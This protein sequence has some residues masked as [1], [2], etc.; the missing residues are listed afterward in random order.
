MYPVLQK[1]QCKH[2]WCLGKTF[3][4]SGQ[5]MI[6]TPHVDPSGELDETL[7]SEQRCS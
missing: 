4:V 3:S 6:S 1:T 7:V 2:F 5:Q